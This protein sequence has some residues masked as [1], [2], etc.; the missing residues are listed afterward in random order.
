VFFKQLIEKVYTSCARTHF[1]NPG[2][3]DWR[4]RPGSWDS[5][6]LRFWIP[7]IPGS[8]PN[9][10]IRAFVNEKFVVAR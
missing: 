5:G 9:S 8:R 3:W 6:I 1:F 4:I 2:I 10:S 7:E